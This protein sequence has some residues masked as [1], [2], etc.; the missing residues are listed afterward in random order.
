MVDDFKNI[1]N[2][3]Q[4]ESSTTHY[5]SISLTF[6]H[7]FSIEKEFFKDGLALYWCCFMSW[8][9]HGLWLSPSFGDARRKSVC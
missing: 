5:Y 6:F 4:D 2:G 7:S 3:T 1:M 8:G 9:A